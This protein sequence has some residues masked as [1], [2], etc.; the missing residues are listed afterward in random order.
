MDAQTRVLHLPM[1]FVLQSNAQSRPLELVTQHSSWQTSVQESWGGCQVTGVPGA[2]MSE[3]Q[4]SAC[5]T[6]SL[7]L[8]RPGRVLV[9][10][11]G[12]AQHSAVMTDA[13]Q[14]AARIEAA[15]AAT[16]IETH[17]AGLIAAERAAS[18]AALEVQ[19][20]SMTESELKADVSRG[21]CPNVSAKYM[22]KCVFRVFC[23]MSCIPPCQCVLLIHCSCIAAPRL[24]A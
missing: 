2:L 19:L 10:T 22:W 16:S 3:L 17:G 13:A 21:L 23:N 15:R 7:T 24:L 20:P 8:L 6:I 18:V 5:R 12:E 14:R 11:E 1:E 9:S 4:H